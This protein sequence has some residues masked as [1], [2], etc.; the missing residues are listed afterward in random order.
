MDQPHKV[1]IALGSNKGDRLKHLQDA[2]NLI[3]SDVGKINIISKVY[4]TPALGFENDASTED[5]LNA[6]VFIDTYFSAEEVMLKLLNIEN[7]L[8]RTR[9]LTDVYESRTIDL[10]VIFFDD[11]VIIS[12]LITT[13][14]AQMHKR[15]FVLQPLHD[16]APKVLHPKLGQSVLELLQACEDVLEIIIILPL[17]EILVREKQAWRISFRMISM[18]NLF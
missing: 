8:G 4:N 2:I 9:H 17:K 7:E 3:F 11:D 14:H 6:C 5:F 16:I 10:D 12:E 15:K 13:P 18:G 1:Y